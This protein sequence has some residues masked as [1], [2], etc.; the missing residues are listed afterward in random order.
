MPVK[1]F[2]NLGILLGIMLSV[3]LLSVPGGQAAD[4]TDFEAAYDGLCQKIKQCAFTRMQ[5]EQNI[6]EEM[7][8]MVEGMLST[9]CE[10]VMKFTE[11]EVDQYHELVG[12]ATACM[13]SMT[14]LSCGQILEE[15]TKTEECAE[16]EAA[17]KEYD[18]NSN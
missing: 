1:S 9:M 13:E 6:T 3:L 11:S 7:R 10:N 5:E 15:Q 8:S 18:A 12:P 17:S 14:D 2:T 4:M 16:F